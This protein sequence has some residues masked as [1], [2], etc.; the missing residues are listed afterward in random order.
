MRGLHAFVLQCD[1]LTGTLCDTG[2][3]GAAVDALVAVDFCYVV[4]GYGIHGTGVDADAATA[5]VGMVYFRHLSSHGKK[6]SQKSRFSGECKRN[7]TEG[8]DVTMCVELPLSVMVGLYYISFRV[9]TS[10]V[11]RGL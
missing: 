1:G 9:R 3:T 7:G 10:P 6:R 11:I 4:Y 8:K 5:S 2:D